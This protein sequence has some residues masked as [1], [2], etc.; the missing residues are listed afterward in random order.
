MVELSKRE[1]PKV[2]EGMINALNVKDRKSKS[3]SK[4]SKE[5]AAINDLDTR[6]Y[7]TD[8]YKGR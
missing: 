3:S 5:N 4:Q 6:A 1:V 8:I 7:G 2:S